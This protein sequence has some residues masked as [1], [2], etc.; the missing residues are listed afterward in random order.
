MCKQMR[1][2]LALVQGE[3]ELNRLTNIS[4]YILLT[5]LQAQNN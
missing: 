5:K 4:V 1:G 2:H 3:T